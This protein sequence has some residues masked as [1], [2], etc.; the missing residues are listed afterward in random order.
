MISVLM[1]QSANPQNT[2][3]TPRKVS[4]HVSFGSLPTVRSSTP[5]T[6]E[7]R[8]SRYFFFLSFTNFSKTGLYFAHNY[9]SH[10]FLV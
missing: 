9:I 2:A 5:D 10:I 1:L 6:T 8:M 3:G 7:S 4:K